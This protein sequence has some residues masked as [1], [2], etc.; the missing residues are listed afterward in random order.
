M[1]TISEAHYQKII[2][3][4]E[5]LHKNVGFLNPTQNNISEV[6]EKWKEVN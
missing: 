5:L 6:Y 2:E 4:I 3:T 1:I